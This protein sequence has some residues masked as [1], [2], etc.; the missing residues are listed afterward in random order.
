ML[1]TP[2]RTK[3]P[4]AELCPYHI[5]VLNLP[6]LDSLLRQ[7]FSKVELYGEYSSNQTMKLYRNVIVQGLLRL[8]ALLHL[9]V[10]VPLFLKKLQ[11][12][13]EKLFTGRTLDEA[14]RTEFQIS[15]LN[16]EEA[17]NI[18]AVCYK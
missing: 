16:P 8:M 1:S 9:K 6:E 15:K 3:R 12:M 10:L 17:D 13:I 5:R 18:I 2:N 4:L 7:F 11:R 14:V